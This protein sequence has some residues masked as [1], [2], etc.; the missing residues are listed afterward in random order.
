MTTTTVD[1]LTA[2]TTH[3]GAFELPEIVSMHLSVHRTEG[4]PV[5]AS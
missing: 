4:R 5:A 2:I 3:L 1:L